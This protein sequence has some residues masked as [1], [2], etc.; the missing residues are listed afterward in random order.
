MKDAFAMRAGTVGRVH[1]DFLDEDPRV[2]GKALLLLMDGERL[3]A[4]EVVAGSDAFARAEEIGQLTNG[5]LRVRVVSLADLATDR[6]RKEALHLRAVVGC[7]DTA[8]RAANAAAVV[9][10]QKYETAV[11]M[12]FPV[13]ALGILLGM[14][15]LWVL[16]R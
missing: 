1:V 7:S 9:M 15:L 8:C 13:L 12:W 14:G 11:K 3:D 16:W 4:V 2:A 10:G 5:I 6:W